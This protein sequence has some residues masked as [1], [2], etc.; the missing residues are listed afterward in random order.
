MFDVNFLEFNASEPRETLFSFP[1]D[2]TEIRP[3]P[4]SLGSRPAWEGLPPQVPPVPKEVRTRSRSPPPS[5][6]L[7]PVALQGREPITASTPDHSAEVRLTARISQRVKGTALSDAQ[8]GRWVKVWCGF[9]RDCGDQSELNSVAL[10]FDGLS[11]ANELRDTLR[12]A[13][14]EHYEL[15]TLRRHGGKLA[16]WAGHAGPAPRAP[17]LGLQD[18][19]TWRASSSSS[20]SRSRPPHIGEVLPRRLQVL[21]PLGLPDVPRCLRVQGAQGYRGQRSPTKRTTKRSEPYPVYN[22][23]LL[24]E[25]LWKLRSF[26]ARYHLG[27]IFFRIH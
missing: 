13:A 3:S 16:A 25:G 10:D 2:L 22:A 26:S 27:H 8:R 24:E 15:L 6:P 19:P 1:G 17:L 14:V 21:P 9:F 18:S 5:R 7:L 12:R 23:R 11:A 20:S 4:S